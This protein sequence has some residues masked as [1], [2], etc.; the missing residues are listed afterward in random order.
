VAEHLYWDLDGRP[1]NEHRRSL[2][3]QVNV[4]ALPGSLLLDTANVD[5]VCVSELVVTFLGRRSVSKSVTR[6][7][8]ADPLMCGRCE[9][10][11]AIGEDQMLS[12]PNR[13]V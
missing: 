4:G 12:H 13:H 10:E 5:G 8:N 11:V 2:R 7:C 9:P 1:E 6:R 3:R